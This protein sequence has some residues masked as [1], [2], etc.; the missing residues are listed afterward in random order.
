M[1][2]FK[3]ILIANRGEI[4]VRVI[5]ACRELGISTVAVYSDVDK[6]AVHVKMADEAVC[7]GPAD[8]S[9][10]YLNMPVILSA[11][12]ITD[13]E[14]IHPGYGFLSENVQ[15]AETCRSSGI[16]FI[17][18][19]P[20]NIRIGGDKAK[21]RQLLKR[22]SVP[23][24]PG[25]SGVLKNEKEARKTAKKVGYPIILKA[26]SGGGGRGMR[27]V[28]SELEMEKS[29]ATAQRESLTAFGSNEL[30]IEK[31]LSSV[32]HIE[33][34]IMADNN[35]NVIHLGERDCTIQRRHQKLI[36]ESPSP[37]ITNKLRKKLGEY[38]I[39]TARAIGYRN[40]GTV[41]FVVNDD[42]IYFI[43]INTRV[44]VEH[45]VTEMVTGIDII[46]EQIKLAAGLPLEYRQNDITVTG[47]AIE[48]RINAEDPKTF[49]PSPG[50]IDFFYQPG[51]AGIRIDTAA[52]SGWE[53]PPQYDSLVAKVIVQAAK[54]DEAIRHML[55]A[56][57]E[58]MIEGI[59]TTIPF[60]KKVLRDK[61]FLEGDFDT[62]FCDSMN[63][64]D[65]I[66]PG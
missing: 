62:H 38:A 24:I 42:S 66:R 58:F 9:L 53:V 6:E 34:Q 2:L 12:E 28:E 45:P 21:A 64:R 22:K 46:N 7:I 59:K 3:K 18:P 61:R 23:V 65:Y 19:S 50:K 39:K 60:H 55:L 43:E 27:I 33:V 48:C 25:S 57:D 26:S 11:A 1:K 49:I 63:S 15:F 41:E 37:F 10:S 8:V 17:G 35:G 16:T 52:Y 14:A 40:V 36:E 20:D 5:R 44:Q 29:F 56:L 13:A 32:R 4:A 51:G 54:R 47:H 31:Y 30:Y